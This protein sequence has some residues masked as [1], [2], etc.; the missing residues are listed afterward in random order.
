MFISDDDIGIGHHGGQ[1]FKE[2]IDQEGS[3]QVDGQVFV[4]GMSMLS[5]LHNS[6][7][8]DSEEERAAVEE[9]GLVEPLLNLLSLKVFLLV[10]VGSSQ[11]SNKRSVYLNV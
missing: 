10:V 7:W 6:V 3:C 11:V 5:N 4:V 9:L 2:E 8:G 1:V